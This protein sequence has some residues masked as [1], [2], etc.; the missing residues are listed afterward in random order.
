MNCAFEDVRVLCEL[1]DGVSGDF[2]AALPEFERRR[3]DN[4]DAIAQLAIENFEEM[5]DLAARPDFQY[6]KRIE[7]ALHEAYPD[8][9][10]P[11]YN[12]VSFSTVPYSLAQAQGRLLDKVYPDTM[13]PQY[14]L[15]SFSTVPYSLAQA[16]V[17]S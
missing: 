14:N 13:T 7:R 1:L 10:T 11:Q 6:R 16:Q 8:T 17:I 9:M 2:G 5:R 3:K 12:L 4:A 15:V